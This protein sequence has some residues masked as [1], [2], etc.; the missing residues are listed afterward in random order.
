MPT[1]AKLAIELHFVPL[2][3]KEVDERRRRLRMLLLRGA[4]R[5][6]KQ[7]KEPEAEALRVELVQK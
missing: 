5:L 6:M 1:A 4:V 2:A 7:V 3:A